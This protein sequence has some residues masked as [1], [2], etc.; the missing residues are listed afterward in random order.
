MGLTAEQTA[1]R[2]E[3]RVV[4]W[5]VV[6]AVAPGRFDTSAGHPVREGLSRGRELSVRLLSGGV[7]V[8]VLHPGGVTLGIDTATLVKAEDAA[9]WGCC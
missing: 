2:T 1:K 8:V 5:T 9:G 3:A 6:V 4:E 7:E